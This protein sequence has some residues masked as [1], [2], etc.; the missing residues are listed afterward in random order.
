MYRLYRIALIELI[1]C[2]I[3]L[4]YAPDGHYIIASLGL[5]LCKPDTRLAF[6]SFIRGDQLYEA[7]NWADRVKRDPGPYLWSYPL[8]FINF[9]E[10][11]DAHTKCHKSDRTIV[12]NESAQYSAVA[13]NGDF[14]L[15][16]TV[17]VISA[18]TKGH[19]D[20][21]NGRIMDTTLELKSLYSHGAQCRW[22]SYEK[23]DCPNQFCLL[24][25]LNNFT[26]QAKTCWE[27]IRADK[28]RDS[29]VD[30]GYA[31][32]CPMKMVELL[33]FVLHLLGDSHQVLHVCGIKYGG[34]AIP[35]RFNNLTT[36]FHM[37][38]DDHL[39]AYRLDQ[40][41][42]DAR[43]SLDLYI[44]YLLYRVKKLPTATKKAM[45]SCHK[46]FRSAPCFLEWIS[47]FHCD[48]AEQVWTF[49]LYPYEEGY[50]LVPTYAD[51]MVPLLDRFMIMAGLRLSH[52]L[53][54]I[55]S[56]GHVEFNKY[57]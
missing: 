56:F 32:S 44:D 54:F 17:R 16:S 36:N 39:V 10:P 29:N 8:H 25:A 57:T 47:R 1:L 34:N 55:F 27:S 33:C 15:S 3:I 52:V 48:F 31:C 49:H 35:A 9:Q 40:F 2:G 53:D 7:A 38:W 18:L 6:S 13:L 37:V 20:C 45:L 28:N 23:G 42:S 21:L 4:A 41:K 19:N 43:S 26:Q 5:A 22:I 46:S 30:T 11:E 24:T 50:D 12:D 51:S 14:E